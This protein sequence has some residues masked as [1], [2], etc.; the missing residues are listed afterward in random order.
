MGYFNW[1]DVPCTTRIEPADWGGAHAPLVDFWTNK[2]LAAED[3]QPS[4]PAHHTRLV[5]VITSREGS[6]R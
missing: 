1:D 5:R 6:G 2:E 4:L 3:L